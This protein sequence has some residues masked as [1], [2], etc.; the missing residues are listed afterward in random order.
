[1]FT[2]QQ[3]ANEYR[4]R[5][6]HFDRDA[7]SIR[8]YYTSPNPFQSASPLMAPTEGSRRG[9]SVHVVVG[10]EA[11]ELQPRT[12]LVHEALVIICIGTKVSCLGWAYRHT[13]PQFLAISEAPGTELLYGETYSGP[14]F[15]QLWSLQGSQ[16]DHLYSVKHNGLTA[17]DIKWL[18]S[19]SSDPSFI[20]TCA[21]ALANGKIE[22]YNAPIIKTNGPVYL[23]TVEIF[24]LEG[25]IFQ[26]LSWVAPYNQL[27]AGS[28]DG[29]LIFFRSGCSR[30]LKAIF[31]A[32]QI[33]V[34]S[35][36]FCPGNSLLASCSLDGTLK[37]WNKYSCTD[38]LTAYKV[39][40]KQRWSYNVVWQPQGKYIFY[41]NEGVVAPHKVI[42]VE[43]DR[44]DKKKYLDI[45]KQA[46]LVQPTQSSCYSPWSGYAYIA[47]SEGH[48]GGVFLNVRLRQELEKSFKKRKSPWS[49]HHKVVSIT[50]SPIG[51]EFN[52][53]T[54][55][56]GSVEQSQGLPELTSAINKLEL[57]YTEATDDL[58]AMSAGYGLVAVLRVSLP[59]MFALT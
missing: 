1:M 59:S 23:E 21:V 12:T 51:L 3:I 29:S 11:V 55:V 47:S 17:H 6:R 28:Q 25:L 27:V 49:L 16:A 10:G 9:E 38:T 53:Q 26:C 15:V 56:H 41:D 22:V 46:T 14:G 20:G 33:T 4:K 7:E 19:L 34:T 18:P 43:Y 35:V 13:E 37:L 45:S 30:P 24:E 36:S 39:L 40:L 52:T 54:E 31:C 5:H 57:C 42:K 8:G 44:F 58:L 48:V 32:H 2:N 50:N